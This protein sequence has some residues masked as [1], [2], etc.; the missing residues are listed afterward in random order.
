MKIL[1]IDPGYHR[2]GYGIIE[3]N[4]NK[5]TIVEYGCIETDSSL[6]LA[7]RLLII[8]KQLDQLIKKHQPDKIG[9]EE[10]FFAKNTKTA[11]KV[12]S[13]RGVILLTAAKSK[14]QIIELTPNQVKLAITGYGGADK[15]QIQEMVKLMLKLAEIPKPDDAADALAIALTAATWQNFAG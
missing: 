9:I 12:A 11:L 6:A 14:A 2:C 4:A 8:Q 1:G 15:R 7:E 3:H 10:I 13:A 5:S